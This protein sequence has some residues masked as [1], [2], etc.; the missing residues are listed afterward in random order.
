MFNNGNTNIEFNGNTTMLYSKIVGNYF[1]E[2]YIP[3]VTVSD[4]VKAK[5]E[6][7]VGE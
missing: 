7:K 6:A 4:V 5:I 3:Y 1:D 2:E